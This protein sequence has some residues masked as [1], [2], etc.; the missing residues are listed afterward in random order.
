MKLKKLKR[1]MPTTLLIFSTIGVIGTY[2]TAA[3]AGYESRM[4]MLELRKNGEPNK[5]EIAKSVAPLYILPTAIA[6]CTVGCIVE[7][8]ILNNRQ[9]T[10]LISSYAALSRVFKQYK[11]K[12]MD[13]YGEDADS[14]ITTAITLEDCQDQQL[15][16]VS[17]FSFVSLEPDTCVEEVPR[18]FYD[19]YSKRYFESTLSKVIQAEYHLNHN[20]SWVGS[21]S[22]NDFYNFLG[23][24]ILPMG[25]GMGWCV[26]DAYYWVNFNH[27]T[28]TLDD[29]M[30][31]IQIEMDDF[32]PPEE[33]LEYC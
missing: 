3:K 5:K 24:D 8:C 20:L 25:D 31:I 18:V 14:R 2:V 11:E 7:A 28:V 17:G 1:A 23:I 19:I 15:Y 10:A 12:A 9:R 26:M 27:K 33:Y 29:G 16:T 13:I 32:S 22:L 21:V 30:E 4:K 6:A